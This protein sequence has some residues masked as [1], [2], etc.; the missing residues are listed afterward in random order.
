M[1]TVYRVAHS[2]ER[3]RWDGHPV[4]PYSNP[5]HFA[6]HQDPSVYEIL[7]LMGICHSGGDTD[8]PSPHRD[9]YLAWIRS[10]ELCGFDSMSALRRWFAEW[11]EA[12]DL[13]GF[14]IHVYDVP[15]MRVGQFGQALFPGAEST[16]V[17]R[18]PLQPEEGTR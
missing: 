9:P 2:V 17:K 13:C 14:E 16:L 1:P 5:E 15:T 12:L 4:G 8:H 7:D 18:I 6:S 11:A 3:S 10:T